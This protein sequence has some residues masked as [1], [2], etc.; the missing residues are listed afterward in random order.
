MHTIK[1]FRGGIRGSGW[2][3]SEVCLKWSGGGGGVRE[4]SKESQLKLL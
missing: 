2:G 1:S 4:V 3:C